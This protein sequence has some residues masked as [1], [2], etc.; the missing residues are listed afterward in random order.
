MDLETYT[1]LTVGQVSTW[2]E[3]TNRVKVKA[4]VYYHSSVLSTRVAYPYK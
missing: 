2:I 1:T 3:V 4:T